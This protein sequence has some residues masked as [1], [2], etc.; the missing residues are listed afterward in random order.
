NPTACAGA[1]FGHGTMVLDARPAFRDA[2]TTEV[3]LFLGPPTTDDINN[4]SRGRTIAFIQGTNAFPTQVLYGN[5]YRDRGPCSFKL[6]LPPAIKPYNPPN[7]AGVAEMHLLAPGLVARKLPTKRHRRGK[8][9]FWIGLPKCT[10]KSLA[11]FEVDYQFV[12]APP[13]VR[14]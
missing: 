6:V 10:P 4:G 13:I 5:V 2:I 7:K 11:Q 3:Y 8:R 1:E 14:S 9:I 12:D